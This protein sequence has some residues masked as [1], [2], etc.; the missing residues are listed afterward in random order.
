MLS[1]SLLP[2]LNA[3]LNASSSLFMIAGYIFI[4][5]NNTIAHRNCMI[6]AVTSSGLFLVSYLVYHA[7]HGSTEFTG[8]GIVRPI[9]FFI[10]ITHIIL[11]AVALPLVL[12]TFYRGWKAYKP[13]AK[14]EHFFSHIK[15]ARVTF[16]IWLYVS[17]TGIVVYLMLYHLYPTK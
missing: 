17:V 9:Y 8:Q 12:T 7:I 15:I 14:K 5:R 3:F 4:R 13:E 16:P 1:I 2:T 11:A 6:G 10:L